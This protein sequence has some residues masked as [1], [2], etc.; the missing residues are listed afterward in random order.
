VL[1]LLAG[2]VVLGPLLAGCGGGGGG[3]EDLTYDE[4]VAKGDELYHGRGTCAVCHGADLR[5]TD[6]GPPFLDEIYAPGHHADTA[7]FAAVENGVRPHHWQFGSMPPLPT[8][9][10][11]DVEAIVAYVRQ[12][13]REAGIR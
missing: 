3:G 1:R 5:G 10:E 8:V 9:D 11:D 12:E 7:F 13:Q 2:L 6:M 4:L